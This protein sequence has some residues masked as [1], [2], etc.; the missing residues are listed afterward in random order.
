MLTKFNYNYGLLNRQI[1][2]WLCPKMAKIYINCFDIFW[3]LDKK[4]RYIYYILYKWTI[5]TIT[6]TFKST[7]YIGYPLSLLLTDILTW[8]QGNSH[9]NW[10]HTASV[11]NKQKQPIL[12]TLQSNMNKVSGLCSQNFNFYGCKRK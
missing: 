11:S 7:F 12:L 6:Y 2:Q 4:L 10:Q 9:D 3:T 8:H 5:I 1:L